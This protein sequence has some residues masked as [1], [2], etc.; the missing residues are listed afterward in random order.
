MDAL[1][2]FRRNWARVSYGLTQKVSLFVFGLL[3]TFTLTLT[4]INT[5]A[6]QETLEVRLKHRA[7]S[8]TA[9]LADFASNYMTDLRIDELRVIVQDIQRRDDILYA[10]VLDPEGVLIVDGEVGDDNLFDEIDDPLSREARASGMGLL[11]LDEGGVHAAEPVY[12]DHQKLGTVRLGMSIDQLQRDMVAL[13]NRNL[14]VGGVF[15]IIGVLVSLPLVRRITRPLEL[16]TASSEEASR[17]KFAQRIDIQTNDE[18]GTLAT[19]FNR[20]LEQLQRRDEQIRHLAYF[21]STTELPNR[22]HFK[23]LLN[24]AI[25]NARRYG[26]KGALLYLDLD[27]FKLINDTLGHD[28]GDRLLQS[29]AQRLSTGLRDADVVAR[30][31]DGCSATVARLGGDE[32]TVML[33]EIKDPADA[34]R[35]AE[36]IL[37]LLEEPF[38]LGNQSVVIGSSIGIALFPDDGEDPDRLLKNADAAMYHAKDQGRNNVQFYRERLSARNLQRI[39]MERELRAALENGEFCLH[40]QP[41]TEMRSWQVVGFEALLRWRHPRQGLILPGAFIALAEETRLI[42]PIGDWVIEQACAQAQSW[43]AGGLGPFRISVNLSA[44]HLQRERFVDRLATLLASS[45]ATPDLLE[46]EITETMM[47]VDPA[48]TATK[49]DAIRALGVTLAIDDFGTGH[50]SLSYLKRFP[51]NRLKIDRSFISDIASDADDEAIV[52]AII[53]MAHNLKVEVV[54][55]GVETER[56]LEFLRLRHCDLIQGYL[57]SKPMPAEDVVPWYLDWQR[58]QR[59]AGSPSHQVNPCQLSDEPIVLI[60]RASLSSAQAAR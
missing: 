25:V 27:R 52:S 54:A 42:L 26:R 49:L 40:Y 3:T 46:L 59:A 24:H 56:Q 45:G 36:R 19:A 39:T 41:L 17:G 9:M 51:L 48:D 15:L 50:S 53:A 34:V 21:D 47:M 14:M 8:I 10:Y 28:A 55:E 22:V 7:H 35:V 20:M 32:F 16:L 44:S 1:A 57:V 5:I 30:L 58:R 23:E 4:T 12:L 43:A 18:I 38:D 33:G 2:G 13:R 6:E 29:F 60:P 37:E 31:V 11:T